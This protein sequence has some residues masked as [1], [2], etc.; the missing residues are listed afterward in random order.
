MRYV[1]LAFVFVNIPF[2]IGCKGT[3]KNETGK[4]YFAVSVKWCIFAVGKT[5]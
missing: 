4:K 2:E 5:D 1:S 3:K